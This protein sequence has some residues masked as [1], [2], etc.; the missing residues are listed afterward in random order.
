MREDCKVSLKL[1]AAQVGSAG[2]SCAW[3]WDN[4]GS[5]GDSGHRRRPGED[6][7]IGNQT[8]F[9]RGFKVAIHSFPLK[10]SAKA[11]SIM[12]SKS[13]DI[14]SKSGFFPFLHH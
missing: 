14:L 13:S 1:K 3:E 4:A 6:E 11:L 2:T 12:D 10:K 5:F 7:R 8:V 9:L